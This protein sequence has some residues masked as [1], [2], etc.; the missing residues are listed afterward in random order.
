MPAAI[1]TLTTE[2]L[3]AALDGARRRQAVVAANI[4]NAG[5][6]GYVPLRLSFEARLSEARAGLREG[7]WLDAGALASV[8]AAVMAPAET[9]EDAG[10][11]Q[12][13]TEMGELAR[14]AVAF[15]ALLQGVSRHLSLLA[16]AA[17]DG[18]K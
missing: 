13:D 10:P 1:E 12:L 6:E 15:Q 3:S 11:V 18:R 14:N 5:T 7:S 17:A 2:A 4:A 8:R 16:L 9:R